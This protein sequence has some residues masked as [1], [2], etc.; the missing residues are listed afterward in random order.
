[1][2]Y[3]GLLMEYNWMEEILGNSHGVIGI[4]WDMI[5]VRT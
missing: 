4:Q 2:M 5:G 3:L 1:M